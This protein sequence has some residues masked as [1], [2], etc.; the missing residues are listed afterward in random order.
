M[1]EHDREEQELRRRFTR[2]VLITGACELGAFAVLG[3]RLFQLQV[4]GHKRY[5]PLAEEN[6]ISLQLLAPKRGRILDRD[7][8][9]LA[10]NEE[11]F[12]VALSPALSGDIRRTL[13]LL[14]RIVPLTPQ[15]EAAIVKR[16]SRRGR[17]LSIVIANDLTFDQVAEINLL[18]PQLPGIRTDVAWRRR[19][20]LGA[21]AAAFVGYVGSPERAG[22]DAD[23]VLR[24]AGM[25][26]GK[27]GI[28]AGVE[29]ELRGQGGSE[30]IEVDARGH[31]VRML[32][33][34]EAKTGA[35]I[36]ITLESRLQERIYSRLEREQTGCCVVMDVINGEILSL[37]SA[38]GLDPG[39][40]D[41]D[42]SAARASADEPGGLNSAV[43]MAVA[44]GGIFKT[45]TALA[46][47]RN[48]H[49]SIEETID[50]PGTREIGGSVHACWKHGGHGPVTL[51]Q[52]LGQS[53]DLYFCELAHRTG[54]DAL[55]QTARDFGLGTMF[56][57]NLPGLAAG[58]LPDPAARMKDAAQPWRED[59]TL[60]SALGLKSVRATPLQLAVLAAR[61]ASGNVLTPVVVKD[62]GNTAGS[63]QLDM[64]HLALAA[65]RQGLDAAVNAPGG[66]L[67]EAA[68]EDGR[69]RLA[70]M[71]GATPLD[72][73]DPATGRAQDSALAHQAII[74]FVPAD[75]PRFAIS[76]VV[77]TNGGPNGPAKVATFLRDVAEM[78]LEEKPAHEA[79]PA[80]APS[81][82]PQGVTAGKVPPV[83]G[84]PP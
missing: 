8:V 68:L 47:L 16:A 13:Q 66:V 7:G 36:T 32:D 28:E 58:D 46:A 24:L 33:T 59:D 4:L 3:A 49:A 34:Q 25:K 30:K 35:D 63:A 27:S 61:L 20:P 19:Y 1:F 10:D 71:M 2:R 5:A 56:D 77:G 69:P 41:T 78:L 42:D 39:P 83:N 81:Q 22:I 62:P 15:T 6:R 84:G 79:A 21:S 55:R 9:V 64:P 74:A 17:H 18:A 73:S 43:A 76:A 52:A 45:V 37:A 12:R 70:G 44:P 67:S 23:P 40:L 72:S 29:R 48:G 14:R 26:T 11:A 75:A 38:P 31:I 50:C 82:T 65:I 60:S 57:C 53:C 54:V 80:G 51:V